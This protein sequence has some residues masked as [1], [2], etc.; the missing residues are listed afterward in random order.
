MFFFI[1]CCLHSEPYWNAT[2]CGNNNCK[3]LSNLTGP[4]AIDSPSPLPQYAASGGNICR[5]GLRRRPIDVDVDVAADADGDVTTRDALCDRQQQQLGS[6]NWKL[7][8]YKTFSWKL[9]IFPWALCKSQ[10]PEPEPESQLV[11]AHESRA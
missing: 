1:V 6:N 9:R 4:L 10:M 3:C 8:S 11:S 5:R 7:L 2:N